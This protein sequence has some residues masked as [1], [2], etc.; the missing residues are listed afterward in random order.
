MQKRASGQFEIPGV[1]WVGAFFTCQEWTTPGFFFTLS[2]HIAMASE[3]LI[4]IVY[5]ITYSYCIWHA[6]ACATA[7]IL[8]SR[9]Y[10]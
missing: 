1:K 2:P 6:A 7:D 4:S 9:V 5:W 10:R 8:Q 3:C